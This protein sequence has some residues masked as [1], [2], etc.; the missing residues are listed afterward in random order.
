MLHYRF[1]TNKYPW[2]LWVFDQ[3]RKDDN[4]KVLELGCG[5]GLLWI[6]NA[7]RVPETWE[8]TLSDFSQGM[9]ADARKNIGNAI[10]QISYEVINIENIPHENNTYDIILANHM[11]YHVPD[12]KKALSEIR[13]VLKKDGIFYATTLG[14][15][16]MKEMRLLIREYKTG[17]PGAVAA[18]AVIDNF[19]LQNGEVQLEEHF[20]DV[21]LKIYENSLAIS[22]AGPF[23]D[24]MY[25]C[26]GM[27]GRKPVL[28]ERDRKQLMEFVDDKIKLNGS[29]IIPYNSGMFISRNII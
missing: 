24:Y 19:S 10:K 29:I 5:N 17:A 8:I 16:Y 26:M 2:P 15:D 22:E 12:R 3:L 25:S 1:G 7:K 4:L 18:N 9:L 11:L 14:S 13:R 27:T 21:T 28:V 23:V 20:N 6:L